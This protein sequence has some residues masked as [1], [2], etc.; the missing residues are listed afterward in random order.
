M[1]KKT[2]LLVLSAVLLLLLILV[3]FPVS[4]GTNKQGGVMISDLKNKEYEEAKVELVDDA[5]LISQNLPLEQKKKELPVIV[6]NRLEPEIQ[7]ELDHLL[8]TSSEGLKEVKTEDGVM[9]DLE[10]HFRTVPVAEVNE[11]GEVV[12]QDYVS[13]PSK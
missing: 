11:R 7:N 1:S 5:D 8:N 9:V 2:L 13:P 6:T 4:V 10:D 3:L 12:V